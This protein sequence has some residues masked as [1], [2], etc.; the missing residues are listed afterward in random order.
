MT[1]SAAPSNGS[2]ISGYTVTAADST[3]SAN[4]GETCT[5][6]GALNCIVTGLTNGDSYTFTVTATNG[7]GTGPSSSPSSPVTPA[8][9][10]GAPTGVSAT[11][12]QNASSK[13]TWSAAPS[14]GEPD[15]RLHGDRGRLDH[16]GQRRGDLHHDQRRSTAPSPASPTATATPSPSPRPTASGPGPPPRRRARSPLR[17]VT[18]RPDRRLGHQRAER[19]LQGDLEC[20]AV[21]R[22]LDQRLH[23]DRGR[24]DHLGQRRGDLHHVRRAQLHRH[25][26]DQ[27]RQLHLHRDRDQRHRDRALLLAVERRH[28]GRPLP[29]A[30]DR[31]HRRL[32]ARLSAI[33]ELDGAR[34]R[35]A[36]IRSPAT[37]SPRPTRRHLANGGETCT[38]TT[39][40]L[41]CT[42]TG[43]H[44]RRLL[45]LHA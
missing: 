9:L 38:W 33:S 4:G 6:T 13:V 12:G 45:H 28:S 36:A 41:T 16:L 24:L 8:A 42:V 14:N 35:T 7:I 23:G 30:P 20:R 34:P 21:E 31:R 37:R 5:T 40:P 1:W 32:A 44:R 18:R 2:P 26:P 39:G 15:Q 43:P 10:P 19:E 27:R 22:E 25:R 3:T 29:G 17:R 11:N